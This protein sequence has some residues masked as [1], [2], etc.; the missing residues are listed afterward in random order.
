MVNYLGFHRS[1]DMVF[2]VMEYC[3][4]GSAVDLLQATGAGLAENQIRYVLRETVEGLKYLHSIGKLHR[5]IKAGNIL[6]TDDGEVKLADFGV[7]AEL[8]KTV[9]KRTTF[10]GTPHWMAPEVVAEA[11][12]DQSV[13]VWALG[14][15]AI[16]MAETVPPHA[17]VHPMRVIFKISREP[18]PRLSRPEDWS[19]D[20]A[21]FVAACAM[22][23][24]AE[25]LPADALLQHPFLAAAPSLG[26]DVLAAP[27]AAAQAARERE[28]AARGP[29]QHLTLHGTMD[30][31][32][33]GGTWHDHAGGTGNAST[34]NLSSLAGMTVTERMG[35]AG[36]G[37]DSASDEA[38]PDD[39]DFYGTF[40]VHSEDNGDG[41]G[42]EAPGGAADGGAGGG[43]GQGVPGG[44][45]A[46]GQPEQ[47]A[48]A[49]EVQ[50]QQQ[51]QGR[52]GVPEAPLY[53]GTVG[54]GD[55]LYTEEEV[56]ARVVEATAALT[57][58]VAEL[59][60]QLAAAGGGGGGA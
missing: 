44:G 18:P 13:D 40:I 25:R 32:G 7:A 58:R 38:A 53:G 19:A 10:I 49:A 1:E 21:D 5:D 27:I 23:E 4:G 54:A 51:Q 48:S 50:Q 26:G 55:R 60:A 34:N 45:G 24:P 2:I 30:S 36:G 9:D 35:Y 20:F 39:G 59:E 57:T 33:S 29:R 11:Q 8:T 52:G 3:G 28:K 6:L 47:E 56:Q 14:V 22:K 41:G 15:T 17:D 42:V 46:E 16:E 43:G 37:A 12:Y 31:N